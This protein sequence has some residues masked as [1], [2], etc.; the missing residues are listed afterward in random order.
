VP[1]NGTCAVH[2]VWAPLGPGALARFLDSYK[3]HDAGAAHRLL[4]LFNGFR[5]GDDLAPWRVLLAGLEYDEL[6]LERPMLDLSAYR[7]AATR[8]PAERYCFLNSF[9][10]VLAD[11]WLRALERTLCGPGVGLVGAT[12]SWASVSSYLRFMFGL[13]G[14]YARLFPDR[15]AAVATLTAAGAR[16]APVKHQREPLEYARFVLGQLHGFA[17][18][19]AAHIRTTGFMVK[20]GVLDRV[21]MPRLPRKIDAYRLESGRQSL[22]AQIAAMKL[23]TLVVARDGRAYPPDQW[24]ASHT[25]WQG[26]QENLLIADNRSEDYELGDNTTRRALSRYAWGEAADPGPAV[27]RRSAPSDHG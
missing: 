23:A 11:N 8:F 9:S 26:D 18:F 14:S 27:S 5:E 25:L 17:P 21:A 13:G 7:E 19:P 16:N 6:R 1:A 15:R 2:L 22:T 20:S 3:R 10:V 12:G 4:I 24:A